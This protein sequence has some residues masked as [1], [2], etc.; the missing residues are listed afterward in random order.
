M[1]PQE[2]LRPLMTPWASHDPLKYSNP[3]VMLR[4]TS[5]DITL[6]QDPHILLQGHLIPHL[7]SQ[8]PSEPLKT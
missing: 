8:H 4:I 1:T 5:T 3:F 6:C 7:C 2:P